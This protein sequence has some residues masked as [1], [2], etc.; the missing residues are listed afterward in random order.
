[1]R[2]TRLLH[3]TLGV[4][5]AATAI[6][7]TPSQPAAAAELPWMNTSL[8]P[9][10]RAHLLVSA[11]TLDQKIAQLHGQSGL[12]PELPEC[13]NSGRHVPGIPELAIPTF[14]VTN[15][16]VGLGGGDCSPQDRATALPVA[17]GLAASFDPSLAYDFGDLIGSEARTLGLHE[18][19]GPGMDMARVGQGGRNFEY[20]GEDP[21]LAG[22]M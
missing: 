12:I 16:P 18:L 17:L 21:E 7:G 14:R 20:F 19:E 5:L 11:M 10:T 6:A 3:S 9:E 22:T 1:M 2:Q 15:G 4:I 13:G 8:T